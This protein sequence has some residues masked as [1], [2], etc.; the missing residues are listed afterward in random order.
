MTTVQRAATLVWWMMQ[1]FALLLIGL[2]LWLVAPESWGDVGGL[3]AVLVAGH[4]VGKVG[5]RR[6]Y[7]IRL[8]ARH[9]QQEARRSARR[10]KASA[11]R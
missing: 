2:G 7:T 8:I 4:V 10:A 9:Y 6:L 3:W 1:S 5:S 11:K